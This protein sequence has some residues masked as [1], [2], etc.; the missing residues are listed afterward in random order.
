[1]TAAIRRSKFGLGL[2]A[3]RDDEDKAAG[4]G[5]V[6]PVYK[7]LAFMASAVFVGMAGAVYGYYVSFLTVGTMFDI[8]LSMQVVLVV[9]LGGRGT[10][11][12]P[13][14]GAFIVVPLAEVTNTSIGGMDAGAIRL[15]MFGGLLLL[16]TMALPKGIIPSVGDL[17]ER[18]RRRG[19]TSLTGA[20]LDDAAIPAAPTSDRT[21]TATGADLLRVD[22]VTLQFGGVRALDNAALHVPA[23]S[24]TALI[25]PNGSGK[26]TLFNVIDGTYAAAS[27]QRDAG[28]T[29]VVEARSHAPGVRRD[30]AD[31][32]AA[33]AL[34]Q[35]HRDGERRRRELGLP[36]A[37]TRPLGGLGSRGS[38]GHGAAGVRGAGR[39]RPRPGHRPL[40]RPAQAGR[41]RADADARPGRD[42][43]RRAGGRYQPDARCNGSP[44]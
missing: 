38:A 19:A 17:I 29:V 3:I 11:W 43:A 26:T 7:A 31:L 30:R 42:P 4:I 1:M 35:P 36:A 28:R 24:I 10:V 25:G 44:S 15:L 40:L 27:R 6:A 23:G 18:R 37:A 32:P 2:V 12:G 16:V 41:A 21:L 33:P 14:L 34:R 9:L 20:R 22:G 5:V 39:L 13:V 8:V